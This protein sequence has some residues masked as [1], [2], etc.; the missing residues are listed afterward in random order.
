MA[1]VTVGI[2]IG[3][4]V[5][6]SA[7]FLATLIAALFGAKSNGIVTPVF[8]VTLAGCV[9][10]S[11]ARAPARAAAELL[12]A[13][14][15]FTAVVP[16]IDLV[17]S[18]TTIRPALRQGDPIS[19]TAVPLAAALSIAFAMLARATRARMRNGESNSVWTGRPATV[20]TAATA[21]LPT[22]ATRVSH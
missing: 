10:W 14:A 4:C 22:E 21:P 3:T 12:I 6:V 2:C 15:V 11:F 17:L 8:A 18:F 16:I 20:K 1:R 9:S 7:T 13:A 19:L 5:A